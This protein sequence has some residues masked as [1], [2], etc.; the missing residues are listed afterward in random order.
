MLRKVESLGIKGALLHWIKNFLTCRRQRVSVNGNT[1][2]W[3]PVTSGV[4]QGSV[5][6]P[7]LFTIFISDIQDELH[8]FV[9]LFAD[10]TKIYAANYECGNDNHSTCLQADLDI[11]HMWSF[12]MQMKFHPDKCKVMHLGRGNQG[13][14]YNLADEKGEVHILKSTR[15][16]KDLG[17][18]IDDKLNFSTHMQTQVTKANRVL[19]VIK[20]TFKYLDMDT[21]LLLYKSLVRPHLEYATVIWSPKTKRDCDLVERVQ[22]RATRVVESISHLPYSERLKALQLPTLLFRR[23]RAD[24]IMMYKIAHGL[25]SL[26]TDSH[27][28]I[29]DRAM[30]TPSYAKNTRGHPYK[31]QIQDARGP[32]TNFFPSRCT[33]TWNGLSARTVSSSTVN[34]FKG[35]LK[36][37]WKH[38]PFQYQYTFSY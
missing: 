22:R 14:K 2:S 34:T 21:F 30:F 4:P 12:R 6:G 27:C 7:L 24:M 15:E 31:Y 23:Q 13:H 33:P 8:N 28:N 20:H 16:E 29:C 9:S 11:L 1:S 37:E 19:G 17:V 18:L 25:V 38:H 10:D 3:K 26:R 5:L 32:R 35:R 36:E